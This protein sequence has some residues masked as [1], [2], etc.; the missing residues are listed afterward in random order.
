MKLSTIFVMT[1]ILSCS[2]T[3]ALSSVIICCATVATFNMSLLDE[4]GLTDLLSE[5]P[6]VA[7]TAARGAA[8]FSHISAL[9]VVAGVSCLDA[10]Q[11]PTN[12]PAYNILARTEPKTPFLCCCSTVA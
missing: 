9:S 5:F 6:V 11:L 12:C 1:I 7:D 4:L 8:S 3:V 10:V 2:D